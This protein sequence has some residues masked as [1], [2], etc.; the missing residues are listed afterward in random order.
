MANATHT[1]SKYILKARKKYFVKK[2]LEPIYI[3]SQSQTNLHA[4]YEENNSNS[5][6]PVTK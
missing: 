3:N 2:K 1:L 6:G 5:S 4:I